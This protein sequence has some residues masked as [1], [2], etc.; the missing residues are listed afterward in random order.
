M[1]ETNGADRWK[2]LDDD[3]QSLPYLTVACQ[4]YIAANEKNLHNQFKWN[5]SKP[6]KEMFALVLSRLFNEKMT[7]LQ[8]LIRNI[9]LIHAQLGIDSDINI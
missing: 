5:K 6:Q 1:L 3:L 2:V 7:R 8:S 9:L 4:P